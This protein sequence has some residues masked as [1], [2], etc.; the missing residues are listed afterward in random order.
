[1]TFQRGNR[2]Y[3]NY[4]EDK[5][6]ETTVG[7][8]NFFRWAIQHNIIEYV[9]MMKTDIEKDMNLNSK[10]KKRIENKINDKALHRC[11]VNITLSFD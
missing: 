3:F 10:S 1:M 4:D 5:Y 7:Q 11:N 9:K 2:I 8:L 6:I